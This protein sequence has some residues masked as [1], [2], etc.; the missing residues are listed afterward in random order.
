MKKL[1]RN[2]L[3]PCLLSLIAGCAGPVG[4]EG[5]A[6]EN[7]VDGQDGSPADRQ[8]HVQTFVGGQHTSFGLVPGRQLSFQKAEDDTAVRV[9]YYDTVSSSHDGSEACVCSWEVLF[10]GQTCSD[11]GFVGAALVANVQ[12][13]ESISVDGWCK[14]IPAGTVNLTVNVGATSNDCDCQT[15]FFQDSVGFIE[16]EELMMLAN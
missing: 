15:G 12:N 10:N 5:P 11:P 1:I 8:V 14:G 4:P 2:L 7:G 16:A 9:T 3:V 13:L 6:G